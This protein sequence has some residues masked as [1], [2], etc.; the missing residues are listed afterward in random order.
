MK[1]HAFS[2][3]EL[4]VVLAVFCVIAMT[5]PNIL[6]SAKQPQKHVPKI[7]Y[8]CISVGDM[9]QSCDIYIDDKYYDSCDYGNLPAIIEKI[10][11]GEIKN[12]I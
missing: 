8:D 9:L 12:D 1:K 2:V 6:K 11:K 5:I 7:D 3:V 4:L 10:K